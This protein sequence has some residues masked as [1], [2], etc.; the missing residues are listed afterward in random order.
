MKK[1]VALCFALLL[2]LPVS[3]KFKIVERSHKHA[4]E[5]VDQLVEDHLV[6]SADAPSLEKAKAICMN[7][8]RQ[9]IISSVSVNISSEETS[10][11][12]QTDVNG[13]ID[14]EQQ[15]ESKV[16]TIAAKLPYVSNISVQDAEIYW[17]LHVDKK[18]AKIF[19]RC[20]LKFPFSSATRT[21]LLREF[22]HQDAQQE[23]KLEELKLRAKN[24]VYVEEIARAIT[25]LDPLIN[26]FFD[27]RRHDEAVALQQNYRKMYQ[28]IYIMPYENQLGEFFYYLM[29]EDRRIKTSQVPVIKSTT[30][31]NIH[32]L[33]LE[34]S[35]YRLSYNYDQARP[36]DE[37]TIVFTYRFGLN[38]L[39]HTV[40]FDVRTTA[41]SVMPFRQAELTLTQEE[42]GNRLDGKLYLRSK[43]DTP[44]TVKE[45]VIE[46]ENMRSVVSLDETFT[47]RG[48][49]ELLFSRK[50]NYKPQAQVSPLMNGSLTIVNGAT[51]EQTTVHFSLPY[52]LTNQ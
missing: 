19:Y 48:I 43:F 44:F 45:V 51:H 3:A 42:Q 50:G 4:P 24:F 8:I 22:T 9:D 17:E 25:E 40:H 14:V 41:M 23:A 31:R 26:Y 27:Q 30:A 46:V 49:H 20:H 37:N 32:V 7:Q 52:Q 28:S 16:K 47:G 10:K 36:E 29:L 2:I 13:K 21:K 18:A 5:W 39:K 11:H 6:V 34:N 1:F 33:P 35:L 12:K 38:T 15:Y